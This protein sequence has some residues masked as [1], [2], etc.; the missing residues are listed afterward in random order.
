MGGCPIE[1]A[2]RVTSVVA[3]VVGNII[4][5]AVTFIKLE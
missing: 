4:N 2:W 3:V 1:I 5:I